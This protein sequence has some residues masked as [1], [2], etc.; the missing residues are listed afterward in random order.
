MVQAWYQSEDIFLSSS[1]NR[2]PQHS[3]DAKNSESF[4]PTSEISFKHSDSRHVEAIL[5][6]SRYRDKQTHWFEGATLK[7]AL[8]KPSTLARRAMIFVRSWGV[9][10]IVRAKLHWYGDSSYEGVKYMDLRARLPAS[11]DLTHQNTPHQG[12]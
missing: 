12:I 4:S 1:T 2:P 3:L 8:I 9:S 11:S 5:E 7:Q 10:A 6:G